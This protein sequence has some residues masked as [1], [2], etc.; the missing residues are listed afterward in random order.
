[1]IVSIGLW[2]L[3]PLSTIFQLYHAV[4]FPGGGNQS[5]WRKSLINRI[6]ILVHEY[7][8]YLYSAQNRYV[9]LDNPSTNKF[10]RNKIRFLQKNNNTTNLDLQ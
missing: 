8:T 6:Y 5:T 10:Y 3:M 2:C 4:R 9:T 1:M 7:K